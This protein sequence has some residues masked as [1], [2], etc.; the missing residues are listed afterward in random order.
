[1]KLTNV[2]IAGLASLA[3]AQ[4]A[5]SFKYE[6]L[7]KEKA[8]VLVVDIQDGLFQLVRDAPD[9]VAYKTSAIAHAAVAQAFD[10]PIV[11][12]S[13]SE[14]G[15]NGRTMAEIVEMHP[16]APLIRREGEVNAWDNSDFRDAVMAAN[17]SQIILAGIATDVCTTFLA[18][19]LREAGFSVW[20]NAEASGTTS[21]VVRDLAN[22]RMAQAGVQVVSLFPIFGELMRDW[23]HTPGAKEL[24][25]WL[26]VYYP[27]AGF[28]ARAHALAVYNGT[29]QEGEKVLPGV[30]QIEE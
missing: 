8:M 3:T 19:S 18:L 1:M 22:D 11:I 29:V 2:L 12:S 26:D 21:S 7:D 20:A 24:W 25:P 9:P 10:L 4:D 30:P 14:T 17:R 6:R 28:V 5:G 15:P 13:S 27:V 16:D 23:R